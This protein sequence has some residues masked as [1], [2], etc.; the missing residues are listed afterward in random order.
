MVP[1][2]T[3]NPAPDQISNAVLRHDAVVSA[4]LPLDKEDACPEDVFNHILWRAMKGPQAPYPE[5]AVTLVVDD[6]DD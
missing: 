5:W 3:I 2:N 4:Q 1:L 6:D